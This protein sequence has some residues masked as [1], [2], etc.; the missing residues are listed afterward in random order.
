MLDP[1]LLRNQTEM[2]FKELA[3]R[4]TDHDMNRY[5]SLEQK[6]KELQVQSETTQAKLKAQSRK[7][8]QLKTAG[9]SSAAALGEAERLKAHLN[10][11]QTELNELKTQF[12]TFLSGLPN[13]LDPS[14][15]DGVDEK[16]NLELRRW[17]QPPVF[18]FEPLDHVDLANRAGWLDTAAAA[19]I[20][21]SRFMVL[22]GELA[23]LHSALIDYM[24]D[25][26]VQRHGYRQVYVPYIVN[27]STLL[28]SGQLPKFEQDLF[29]LQGDNDFYLIPTAEVPVTNLYRETILDSEQ[30][31][32]QFVCHTPC[33]RSEA[34]AYGKDTRGLMRQ[35]QFEKVELV[36]IVK[37]EDSP[38]TLEH[39][40]SHAEAVL[41]DLELPYRVVA[42]CSGDL[43]F[44]AAK[45]YDI[46]VWV[47]S[48]NCYREISSCSNTLDFQA[49][50]MKTRVRNAKGEINYVHT[51]NGS[52]LA[53]GR[54]LLALL[55][56][57]QR[58]DGSVAV[59]PAL[60]PYMKGKSVIGNG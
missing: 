47:P 57:R 59:P 53:I 5:L 55:E 17:G 43:G 42:L 48:E 35:H 16:D 25:L 22:H 45:T 1:K 58:V 38:E 60:Q 49:R 52:G 11:L 54:T 21:G 12:N 30:L 6:R 18:D 8:A 20:S 33:F 26:H 39:L 41:Q 23:Q 4:G 50:R 34:G 13:R 37:P 51:L 9:E 31:P 44:A 24:V 36:H 27:A 29:K 32:M 10:R 56:N 40:V 2:V 19:V 15:P 28:G 7:I 3:R 46:E 14:V